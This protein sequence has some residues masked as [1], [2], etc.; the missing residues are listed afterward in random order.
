M[1]S[2]IRRIRCH[3]QKRQ[4]YGM[5]ILV[6]LLLGGVS[7]STPLSAQASASAPLQAALWRTVGG[8]GADAL[9]ARYDRE[10]WGMESADPRIVTTRADGTIAAWD[11]YTGEQVRTIQGPNSA[12][13][14]ATYLSNGVLVTA[15]ADGTLH[16][17]PIPTHAWEQPS[18]TLAHRGGVYALA[19]MP[20][21]RQEHYLFSAG[22]D[23]LIKLWD[24][25]RVVRTYSGHSAAVYSL[26]WGGGGLI[27][28]GSDGTA[29]I[30]DI[31]QATTLHIFRSHAGAVL[32]AQANP[33]GTRL[34]TAGVDGTARV[35]DIATEQ[36]LLVLRGHHG[37]VQA[38]AFSP[39]G[40]WIATAGRDGTVR[41]WDAV[42]GQAVL[43]ISA[44]TAAV[45]SL[46]WN[47][48]GDRLLTASRDGTVK[49][50]S[51]WP[52]NERPTLRGHSYRVNTGRYSPDG[53]AIVTGGQDGTA[54]IWDAQTGQEQRTLGQ[55]PYNFESRTE[56]RAVAYR[57]DGRR[58]ATLSETGGAQIWDAATGS[59]LRTLHPPTPTLVPQDAD[60][61][62]KVPEP[63][64]VAWSPDGHHQITTSADPVAWVW[65]AG[66]GQRL[67]CLLGHT[68]TVNEAAFSPD[69]H[70]IATAGNDRTVRLWDAAT[71]QPIRTLTGHTN[72]VRTVDWSPDSERILSI[73]VGGEIRI[74]DA[75]TGQERQVSRFY[76]NPNGADDRVRARYSPDGSAIAI[77]GYFL[78]NIII[79]DAVTGQERARLPQPPEITDIAWSPDGHYLLLTTEDEV[80]HQLQV[81]P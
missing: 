34:V 48:G 18:A 57:P 81:P 54:R 62:W 4:F 10:I 52:T 2:A 55:P 61:R 25:G 6:S 26:A 77:V 24:G 71:G 42:T 74:W 69:G 5:L 80:A 51:I 72:F 27:S 13:W 70:Y 73:S 67:F 78:K 58:I 31:Y 56:I 23:S 41:L 29:R 47:E 30:W 59:L 39:D 43:V 49:I 68:R 33:D 12:A 20:G 8:P 1:S 3:P 50:W 16:W 76:S 9:Y 44:H 46:A 14:N 79:W 60:E 65:D 35:W 75:A 37:A 40:R 38:A 17:W 19:R 53:R 63:D 28:A 11:G 21:P 45:M 36:A 66:T 32:D 22:A 64:R 7:R 15:H